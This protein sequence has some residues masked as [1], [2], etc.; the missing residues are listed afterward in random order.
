MRRHGV[1]V[2]WM[3]L[4][5]G[6]VWAHTARLLHALG[7]SLVVALPAGGTFVACLSFDATAPYT[8]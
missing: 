8:M 4:G 3:E 6:L 5:W 2:E 1:E 7:P